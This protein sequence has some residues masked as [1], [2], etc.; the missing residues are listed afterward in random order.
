[1]T[2][3]P[4][5]W[6]INSADTS[7][8]LDIFPFLKGQ[9]FLQLKTP[10]WSTKVDTAVNGTERRRALWSY[11]VWKFKVQHQFLRA[12]A[13]T[14][15]LQ[16]LFNFFNMKGGSYQGFFFYDRADN[17]VTNQQIGVGNGSAT[18]FQLTRTITFGTTTFTEPVRGVSGT[19]TLT[20]GGAAK[21]YGTDYTI[22]AL[23]VVTFTTAPGSGQAIVWSGNFFFLCRFGDDEI[24]ASQMMNNLWSG[25]GLSFQ[26]FKL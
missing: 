4:S 13:T 5:R 11:P 8:D 10:L 26:T 16:R 6:K 15:E 7:D 25:S 21:T 20:V 23:G 3:L 2:S 14:Q 9:D 19:P 17:T 18:Q 22:G 1:M 12:D 24:D